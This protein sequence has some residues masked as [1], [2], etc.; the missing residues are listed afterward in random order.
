MSDD[1]TRPFNPEVAMPVHPPGTCDCDWHPPE[2]YA[3]LWTAGEIHDVLAAHGFEAT[4]NDP[5]ILDGDGDPMQLKWS[6]RW[7]RGDQALRV[8]TERNR[9]VATWL[10]ACAVALMAEP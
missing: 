1:E 3:R 4:D 9:P 2:L 7:V 8:P 10:A 5:N 6:K